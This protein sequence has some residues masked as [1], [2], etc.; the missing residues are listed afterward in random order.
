MA[1]KVQSPPTLY[2]TR[3]IKLCTPGGM[4]IEIREDDI[5]DNYRDL[6]DEHLARA[7]CLQT[8]MRVTVQSIQQTTVAPFNPR[9]EE[10]RNG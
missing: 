9:Y 10:P 3:S 8:G 2:Q 6:N 5:L 1:E 7:Y 4:V